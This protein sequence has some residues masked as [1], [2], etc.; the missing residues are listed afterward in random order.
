MLI[1]N[2]CENIQF[3][4]ASQN[5]LLNNLG[6]FSSVVGKMCH[7]TEYVLDQILRRIDRLIDYNGMSTR[8]GL[9]QLN[10]WELNIYIY[11]LVVDF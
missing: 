2:S 1:L 4:F 11:I 7:K 10:V 8:L 5:S 9:F 6:L 3:M